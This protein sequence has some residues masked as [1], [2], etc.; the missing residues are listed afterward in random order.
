M[1]NAIDLQL[2]LTITRFTQWLKDDVLH[3]KWLILLLIFV[4]AVYL[5]WK[6]IDKTRLHEIILFAA[7]ASM[8]ILVMD[9]VGEELT[10][11]DYPVDIFPLF[12]PISAIDL[13]ALP[14]LYAAIYQYFSQWKGYIIASIIMSLSSCF[15]FEPIFVWT[16]IYQ[17]ITWKSYYGLPLYFAIGIISRLILTFIKSV[18]RKRNPAM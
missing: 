5:W 2:Q 14:F 16:G 8:M 15:V 18:S 6:I 1:S 10:L 13:S 9:E 11:W 3:L 7:I 12:P 4:M 17:M